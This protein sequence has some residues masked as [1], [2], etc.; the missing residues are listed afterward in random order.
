MTCSTA[1]RAVFLATVMGLCASISAFADQ[2]AG[3]GAA[4]PMP[5][6]TAASVEAPADV[7]ADTK[8]DDLP[9]SDAPIAT[10]Q[11]TSTR[12]LSA[13]TDAPE[14][15]VSIEHIDIIVENKDFSVR[16]RRTDTGG[17]LFEA[18]PIFTH[19]KGKALIEG[20]V[21]S[22]R[23][24]QDG[25]LLAID[26]AS[27]EASINGQVRGFL[28]GWKA[29][30]AA[31]TWLGPNAI[32]FLTG[33]EPK[34]DALGR[35]TFTLSDQL[36]PKFD[37]DLWIEGEQVTNPE[38]EPRTIGPILLVPLLEVTTALGHTVERL[39]GN[40]VSVRRL[41]DSTTILLNLS[42]GLVAIN[43]VPRGVTP[44]ISFADA[45]TLL[46]PFS[47]V[48]TLTGTHID[49][50]PGTDRI[51]ITLDD[52]LGGGVLPGARV[53]EEV[54]E[55]GFTPEA[56]DFQLSDRGPTNLTFS[57]R[58]RSLN[59]QLRY[60]SVGGFD[61]LGELQPAF[62]GLNV[63]SLDGWV[64]SIGDTNTRL[65]ELS[66]VGASR[67]RGVTWRNQNETSG[68]IIALAAGARANGSVQVSEN[69]SRPTFGGFV[70]GARLL[71]SDRSQ[72][73]GVS[74]SV[75]PGG[76]AGRLVV[77]GQ[78]SIVPVR[79]TTRNGLESLFISAD[80]GVFTAPQGTTGD[81]RGRI[82]ARAR[83]AQQFGIQGNFDY[84]GGRFRQSDQ[85]LAEAGAAGSPVADAAS[86]FTGAVSTDWRAA[87]KWG[88]ISGVAAGVRVSHSRF[89]GQNGNASTSFAG[90]I[91]GQI[92]S[93]E[94][95]LSSDVDYSISRP[96]GS[97]K[98]TSRNIN[99]RALKRFDWGNLQA[100]FTDTNSSTTGQ[101][102]R[103]ISS[104]NIRPI[105]K[106]F[107]DGATVAAGPTASLV[108]A[109]GAT[110]ARFG[111]TVSADSGQKFGDKFSLRGQFS[112]LQSV[113]PEDSGTQFF[114]SFS[115][116]YQ[117]TRNIEL[118]STYVEAFNNG[119]N[120]GI[121]VRGHVPFNEPRK[122]TQPKDGLGVLTG[123]VYFDRNRD[124]VR[125]DDE[126]GIN[127][128]R[129]LVSGTRLGLQ[130]DR[131][132]RFTIQNIKEGLYS[133]VVDRRSL[134]L[135]LVVPDDVAA[136][137]TVSEGRI[138]DLE[139]PI[140]ASGQVRGALFVDTNGN[141]ETDPGETRVEGMYITLKSLSKEADDDE[142]KTQIS[143]SFGQ[144]SFEN[145]TPG[146]YELS[147]NFK[148][149]VYTQ[150]VE[151]N[152]DD[153]FQ[154]APFALP[155]DDG[156]GGTGIAPDF[157]TETTGTA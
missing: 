12:K 84:E 147:V 148:G 142:T 94:L 114:A 126:P 11:P 55:T 143:A 10:S 104:L 103:F 125:Q 79:D 137:A 119:R 13:L 3:K 23:R 47:A 42:T 43:N 2:T 135:G 37:L 50:E 111:A 36:R 155:P 30:D 35:W 26:M 102:T 141:G 48:E 61:K 124:G 7:Q 49:L 39:D 136:R 133:L 65:R 27:G 107:G 132:G 150:I 1:I 127:A 122:Y 34:E 128:V 157:E 66:G 71:K 59:S 149:I 41:Q 45:E 53:D 88:P 118:Q 31:D 22:Y 139:I 75:A 78:K 144:Y 93:L 123:S 18:E 52:R 116:T 101:T 113:A 91:N 120:V 96:T 38:I 29:R 73:F 8:T 16:S 151:L 145:L 46:L 68:N 62:V 105:R 117:L 153:L 51:N 99:F 85:E 20:T 98:T 9:P 44:N 15:A 32:A 95:N 109:D 60:D 57:S 154:I 138:T 156:L 134:P 14:A 115:S 106:N 76:K 140:I 33:T 5:L 74:L 64:G 131:D 4:Q 121:A 82:Q 129:V 19:L 28:P 67:I 146:R 130:V 25:V 24:Y 21:L 70:A 152:E 89:G 90:S 63:Q 92:P 56:L 80:A 108:V 17:V 40:V 6:E 97:E 87:T 100:T 86:S 110:S 77:G 54:A 83:V 69:A 81:I 72:D 58:Y 112:A